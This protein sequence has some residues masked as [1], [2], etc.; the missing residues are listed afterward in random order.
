MVEHVCTMYMDR[1]LNVRLSAHFSANVFFI[2]CS[3][4]LEKINIIKTVLQEG[5]LAKR[6]CIQLDIKMSFHWLKPS[7][8]ELAKNQ[9]P[10]SSHKR[11]IQIIFRPYGIVL[12]LPDNLYACT[13]TDP[14]GITKKKK[15]HKMTT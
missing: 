1:R 11:N 2:A 4:S 9:K 8:I 12:M 7:K 6:K 14:F 15:I 3:E 5:L 13:K 10:I